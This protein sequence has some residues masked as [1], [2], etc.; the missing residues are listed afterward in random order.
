[1][2][3]A[4]AYV[5]G[6]I[7][8]SIVLCSNRLSTQ[9]EISEVL[10]HELVHVYDVFVRGMDLRQCH[11]LAYSE[12]RSAREAEC[13]SSLTNFTKGLCAKEKASVATRNM[14][15][16]TGRACVCDVFEKAM[17]DVAPLGL[18]VD[19]NRTNLPGGERNGGGS[20]VTGFSSGMTFMP[21]EARPSER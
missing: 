3:T 12:V 21:K 6:P 7:P 17:S 18:K 4:R 9:S 10:V 2:P 19:L 8:L 14:F 15:P 20:D 5:R 1:M 16:D 11:S 13:N